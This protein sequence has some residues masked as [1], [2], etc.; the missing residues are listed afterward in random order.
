[1]LLPHFLQNYSF[2]Q[3]EQRLLRKMGTTF[4]KAR[5]LCTASWWS[6]CSI[7]T[8]LTQQKQPWYHKMLILHQRQFSCL[9]GH[10]HTC[11]DTQI[12]QVPAERPG[13]WLG[14]WVYRRAAAQQAGLH[15]PSPQLSRAWAGESS[16]QAEQELCNQGRAGRHLSWLEQGIG[17]KKLW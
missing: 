14:P 16:L 4:L 5:V 6:Y 9:A 12:S 13:I 15:Q 7:I 3:P 2:C 8:K 17:F 10:L 11:T 1:M